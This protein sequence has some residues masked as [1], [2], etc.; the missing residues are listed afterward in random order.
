[1]LTA[2][3]IADESQRELAALKTKRSEE[4]ARQ[5]D[6]RQRAALA[7]NDNRRLTR[8]TAR[9]NLMA[10]NNRRDAQ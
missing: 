10:D 1:V 6:D 3:A 5:L 2:T 9:A 7:E 4:R 8:D